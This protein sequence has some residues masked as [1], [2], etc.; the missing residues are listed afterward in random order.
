MNLG[1]GRLYDELVRERAALGSSDVVKEDPLGSLDR[2]VGRVV[3]RVKDVAVKRSK[4]KRED[5]EKREERGRRTE[6]T[7]SR[8]TA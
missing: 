8:R 5:L 3:V 7:D 4:K 6:L 1:S 2:G